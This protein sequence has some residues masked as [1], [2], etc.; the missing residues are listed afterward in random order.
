M[1]TVKFKAVKSITHPLQLATAEIH[2]MD[3]DLSGLQLLGFS[4]WRGGDGLIV[5]F[6]SYVKGSDLQ[7]F[8]LLRPTLMDGTPFMEAEEVKRLKQEILDGYREWARASGR[9]V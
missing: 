6:P 7:A 8:I 3:G 4:V 2:F 1:M 9:G 5:H